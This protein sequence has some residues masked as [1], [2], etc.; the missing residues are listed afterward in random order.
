MTAPKEI[1]TGEYP[2]T[3]V[4]SPDYSEVWWDSRKDDGTAELFVI[5]SGENWL[6]AVRDF[7]SKNRW[8]GRLEVTLDGDIKTVSHAQDVEFLN[9]I[10]TWPNP[11]ITDSGFQR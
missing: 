9:R 4:Y 8:S 1:G 3:R 10:L 11:M 7:D 5:R 6:P 2:W